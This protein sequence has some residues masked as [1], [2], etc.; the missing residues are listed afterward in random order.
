[1]A[2]LLMTLTNGCEK[3]LKKKELSKDEMVVL[4]QEKARVWTDE[5]D[6]TAYIMDNLDK[7]YF[8]DGLQNGE[9]TG[10]ELEKQLIKATAPEKPPEPAPDDFFQTQP[11]VWG[12]KKSN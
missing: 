10:E 11:I 12:R 5:S 3:E 1:M 6:K 9:L 7:M 8:D 4:L 2:Q